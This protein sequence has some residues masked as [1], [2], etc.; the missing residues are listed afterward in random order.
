VVLVIVLKIDD[1]YFYYPSGIT[2]IEEFAKYVNDNINKFLPLHQLLQDR[3][4]APYF[5]KEDT[6]KTYINTNLITSFCEK[7]IEVL[8]ASDYE[9]R[10]K[11]CIRIRC[12]DCENYSADCEG[13]NMDGHRDKLSLDGSCYLYIKNK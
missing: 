4:V 11:E 6:E 1:H 7:N 10:L 13:D 3:C 12:K 5:I 8:S 9:K 2:T